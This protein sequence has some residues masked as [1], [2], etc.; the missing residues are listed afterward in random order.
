[1]RQASRVLPAASVVPWMFRIV[2]LMLLAFAVMFAK[3]PDW[4]ALSFAFAVYVGTISLFTTTTLNARLASLHSKAEAKRV[5]GIIA[6]G[7]QTGQ[8]G[9]SLSAPILFGL[10][11]NLV[12]IPAALL[13]EFAVQL[14]ACRGKIGKTGEENNAS[15]QPCGRRRERVGEGEAEGKGGD[16]RGGGAVLEGG[17]RL[18]YW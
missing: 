1:M 9:S 8:L 4:K 16:A 5:Y 7:S 2:S 13:Y 12:V 3:F 14:I 15:T 17:G 18:C 10:L 6:A 11:G